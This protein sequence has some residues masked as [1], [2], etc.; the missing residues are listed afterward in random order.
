MH[1][2]INFAPIN[3]GKLL[4]N[5]AYMQLGN[6]PMLFSASDIIIIVIRLVYI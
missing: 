1:T 3:Q 2:A 6:G 4:I 5:M